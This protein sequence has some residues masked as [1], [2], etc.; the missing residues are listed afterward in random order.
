MKIPENVMPQTMEQVDGRVAS[1]S[2]CPALDCGSLVIQYREAD[3]LQLGHPQDWKFACSRC[4]AEFTT[5]LGELIFQSIPRRW[6]S[7][8]GYPA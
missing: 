4:G 8:N 7:A 5:P 6:L 2:S 3:K 1:A